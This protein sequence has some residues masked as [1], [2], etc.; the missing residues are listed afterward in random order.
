MAHDADLK[1]VTD[2]VTSF[3][4][5]NDPSTMT[6]VEFRGARYD[7]GLAW[8]HFPVKFGGLGVR[9]DLN[10]VVES[11]MRTAGAGPADPTSFF[12]ALAG[13]TIVTHG[14]DA[15]RDRFLRPMFTGEETW[16]QL[17]SEPGAGSDFAGLATKAVRD[18]DEWIV[19]GQKV[20][21]TMAHL[22][23]WGM[24]VTRTNPDSPKHK[25]M[26][27]F[28]VDMTSPGVEVRP[29][30]QITGEAEFNEVYMTDVRI[31]DDQRIGD[32][33]E[34]WRV[35]LT[36]LMNE[37]TAIG[38]GS[39]GGGKPQRG[40][41]AND[42]VRI[43]HGLD[44]AERTAVRRD[45]LMRLWVRA[46]VGRLT[47]MRA[48]SAAR[49]G[50]PG[51]EGSVA[52]LEFANLN[53]DLYSFCIDLMGAD[54]LVGYDYTFRRPDELDATGSSK[55]PQYSFLRVRANSIEGGTSEILKNII[56][57]QVLGLPGEPRVDKDVPWI[58]V[59]RS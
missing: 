33:G 8:V 32:E 26:T 16:C 51:P 22:A 34:G 36:T 18:G 7:A 27:Y 4:A 13:P 28:A 35:S 38:S 58:E 6:N 1:L 12:M 17:F 41:A 54:G 11:Q 30:R 42:A 15:Q 23:D 20:W 49:A 56:G 29:L 5:D 21:N 55:G 40:A 53:K 39:A 48:A 2:A 31:G 59:P 10:R 45:A 3:L 47:N 25:G 24:L 50:N 43:F 37:R 57:E 44:D 14:T 52:K 9:P 19:N 46:E